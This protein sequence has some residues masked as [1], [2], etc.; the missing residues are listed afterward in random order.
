VRAPAEEIIGRGALAVQRVRGDQD[1][2]QVRDGVT[3][4]RQ[5]GD[6]VPADHDHLTEHH[7]GGLV[8]GGHQ[9]HLPV[10]RAGT[11]Q[12]LAIDGQCLPRSATTDRLATVSSGQPGGDPPVQGRLQGCRVDRGQHPGEGRRRRR[13]PAHP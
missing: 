6:L 3:D 8:V 10:G 13:R 11:A 1:T 9:L 2:V 12:H 7:P 5:R 4:H